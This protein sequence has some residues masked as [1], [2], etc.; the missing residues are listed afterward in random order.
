MLVIMPGE[1]A[2]LYKAL[3]APGHFVKNQQQNYTKRLCKDFFFSSTV[4]TDLAF[5]G[6]SYLQ[7]KFLKHVT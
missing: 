7:G 1:A 3:L 2:E 5:T 6:Q 4:K